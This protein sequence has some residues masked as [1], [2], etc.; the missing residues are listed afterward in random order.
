MKKKNKALLIS[1]YF[2]P[3]GMGGTQRAAKFAKYLPKYDWEPIVITVKDVHYYAQDNT[4]LKEVEHVSI[5]R[6]ESLDPLR[7]LAR[8]RKNK[9][10]PTNKI[11][12][13]SSK[14]ILNILNIYIGNWFLIPDSKILWVPFA[15]ITAI[16][17]IKLHKINI[18]FTTSPPHSAHFVGL[19][20]KMF[21]SV[22]WIADFRDD[23]TGGESQPCPTVI[24]TIIN[25]FLEKIVLKKADHIVGMC[26]HLTNILKIKS[27]TYT[28]KFSTIMNGYDSEDFLPLLNTPLNKKFTITHCGSIS[29]V[30]DPEPFL[31]A[32]S[33]LFKEKSYLTNQINIQFIG[34]D[35]FGNLDRILH[36]YDLSHIIKPIKYLPH[37]EALS[38]TMSS[39]MLLLTIL[40]KS[41]EEIITGKIFEYL[42]SGKFILLITS[43]G[44]TAKLVQKLQKGI[45]IDPEDSQGLKNSILKFYEM[46]QAGRLFS[47]KP[48]SVSQFD[49]ENQTKTLAALFS[50]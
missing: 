4:L 12:A 20:T 40:K 28:N 2:P 24:H 49:R 43:N 46:Y 27:S 10:L 25:K 26:D 9:E 18:I 50:M 5:I 13:K 1:Y 42:A 3:M 23:W 33:I 6:T 39:H 19:I 11:S 17:L 36:K 44:Y 37:N 45:I 8:F 31:K 16:K 15:V 32:I 48:L 21:T 30:S 29:K 35:I 38:K 34:A 47:G 14:S 7:L 22:K 41:D